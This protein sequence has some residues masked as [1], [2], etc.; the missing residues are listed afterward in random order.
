MVA[1]DREDWLDLLRYMQAQ[2]A[3]HDPRGYELLAGSFEHSDDPR[4]AL[5]SYIDTLIKVTAERSGG[6][7]GWVLD[8]LNQYVRTEDGGPIRSIR[9]QL[10]EQEAELYGVPA[11]ELAELPDR[12]EFIAELRDLRDDL[13][14][15]E[16]EGEN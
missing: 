2:L 3:D 9:V 13:A 12:S 1:L 5:L 4:R 8:Y 10:S 16:A 6:S 15:R 11:V 14:E 7:H